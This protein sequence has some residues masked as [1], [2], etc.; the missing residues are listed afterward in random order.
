M[1]SGVRADSAEERVGHTVFSLTG[2]QVVSA[3]MI[4]S[5]HHHKRQR[6]REVTLQT[7]RRLFSSTLSC[8]DPSALCVCVRLSDM[9]LWGVFWVGFL[10]V[11]VCVWEIRSGLRL[12]RY[13]DGCSLCLRLLLT[14][15]V[16]GG[17]RVNMHTHMCGC[18]SFNV[19]RGS[20]FACVG[21]LTFLEVCVFVLACACVPAPCVEFLSCCCCCCCCAKPWVE[22]VF[23]TPHWDSSGGCIHTCVLTPVIMYIDGSPPPPR[24]KKPSSCSLVGL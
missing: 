20:M 12:A 22:R 18:L 11:C 3:L 2:L 8:P 14:H 24:E 16:L 1:G 7:R 4:T 5:T 23:C 10:C 13:T 19:H 21:N 15:D 6:E 9:C 17:A